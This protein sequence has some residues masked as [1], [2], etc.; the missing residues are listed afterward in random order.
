MA[1]EADHQGKAEPAN[2]A[3][4]RLLV[5]LA[6]P[7][8]DQRLL[9]ELAESGDF[10]AVERCLDAEDLLGR[11]RGGAADAV[12]L[13]SGLHRLSPAALSEL[14]RSRI[15]LV[16]L[17]RDQPTHVVESGHRV[18]A[19]AQDAT[20]AAVREAL[21]A[22]M[23]GEVYDPGAGARVAPEAERPE[24]VQT[25]SES[26]L[27]I[28]VWGGCG[29]PGRT[30]V[31][32]N[33]ATALGSVA[34]AVLA[35]LDLPGSSVTAYL[36]AD[37]GRNI[38]VIAHAQP[39]T[40]AEWERAIAGEAQPLS[41]RSDA[42][43]LCGVPKAEMR[44]RLS[45]PFVSNLLEALRASYRYVVVDVGP[46][47]FGPD[48][49]AHRAVLERASRILVVTSGD[50]VGLWQA[51]RALAQL[52]THVETGLRPVALVVNRYE[53]RRH[54]G[55]REI[56]WA[57]GTPVAGIIPDDHGAG[58]RAIA[59]QR[60]LVLASRGRGA[61]ALLELAGR[62]HQGRIV[63]PREQTKR[64]DRSWSRAVRRLLGWRPRL[65]QGGDRD[66]QRIAV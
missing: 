31:A 25:T 37:P 17:T 34:P 60:P 53:P 59:A 46:D 22:V 48:G 2:L 24:V 9:P 54:H 40:P 13:E 66:K 7:E 56:E 41:P 23:A 36:D 47:L 29:S 18:V 11:V 33:L 51:Q 49:A 19:L 20:V 3:G 35:D 42:A 30:T 64:S 6:D 12:L 38:C 52:R 26:G 58:Q 5:A 57:L 39:S 27:L 43:V 50:L 63:L 1:H 4:V 16:L 32:I 61:R 14:E 65:K 45:G 62:I 21:A 8:L 10:A 15:P 28:A 55:R 44:G